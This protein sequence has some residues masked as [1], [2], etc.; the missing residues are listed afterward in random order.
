MSVTFGQM[1]AQRGIQNVFEGDKI[2]RY[3]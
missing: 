2:L 1:R 3:G